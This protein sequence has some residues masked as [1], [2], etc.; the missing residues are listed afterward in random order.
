M[1]M[2]K[3]GGDKKPGIQIFDKEEK[4]FVSQDTMIKKA[5]GRQKCPHCGRNIP[6]DA[7]T[8]PFCKCAVGGV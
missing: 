7:V 2:N 5:M 1:A 3:I 4:A 6:S 8:C